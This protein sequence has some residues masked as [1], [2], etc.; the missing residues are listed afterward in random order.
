MCTFIGLTACLQ[1]LS[2]WH[3][4]VRPSGCYDCACIL[5][6]RNLTNVHT[7]SMQQHRTAHSRSIYGVIITSQW[8]PSLITLQLPMFAVN[9]DCSLN[10]GTC[11]SATMLSN[12]LG[13]QLHSPA[14]PQATSVVLMQMLQ[15]MPVTR[16][17][18]MTSWLNV[19]YAVPHVI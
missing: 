9:V 15:M 1:W 5:Q 8:A 7:A 18:L 13:L 19:Q 11:T 17:L 16:I 2:K 6:V 14:S 3:C 4:K 12:T 10:N